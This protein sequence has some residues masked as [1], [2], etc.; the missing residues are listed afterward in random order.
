MPPRGGPEV[1]AP[2]HDPREPGRADARELPQEAGTDTPD[3]EDQQAGAT[4]V[5]IPNPFASFENR[6]AWLAALIRRGKEANPH[7]VAD[8]PE[9]FNR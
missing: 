8:Q 5:A 7:R 3:R 1:S 6:G 9:W 2:D 4:P